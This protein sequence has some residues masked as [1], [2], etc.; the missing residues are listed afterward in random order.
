MKALHLAS[1]VA[2]AALHVAGTGCGPARDGGPDPATAEGRLELGQQCL[3]AG[4]ASEAVDHAREAIRLR[5]AWSPAHTL[6]GQALRL[7]APAGADRAEE[8]RAFERA[9]ELRP[10]SA[11]R[12]AGR[13]DR[14]A[15]ALERLQTLG[16]G[17]PWVAE[18]V[19]EAPGE[20]SPRPEPNPN[21]NQ[22]SGGFD[23]DRGVPA[24]QP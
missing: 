4:R 24:T 20:P 23:G 9:V 1:L 14:A 8:V 10:G 19:P 18:L 6:L 7:A 21:P 22:P 12:R 11:Y 5:P 16:T 15:E 17:R 13:Q 2:L 3:V